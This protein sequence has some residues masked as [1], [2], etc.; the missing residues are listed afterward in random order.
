MLPRTQHEAFPMKDK[1][2]GN[3]EGF[4]AQHWYSRT[5]KGATDD[6]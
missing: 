5:E 2:L 3:M 4:A 1:K 6:R